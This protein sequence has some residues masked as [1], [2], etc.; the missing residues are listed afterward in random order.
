M[1]ARMSPIVAVSQHARELLIKI[2]PE[3]V[4]AIAGCYPVIPRI[5][6]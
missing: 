4:K 5:G 6:P 1:I 2:T 3:E